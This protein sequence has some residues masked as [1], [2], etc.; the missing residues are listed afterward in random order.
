[1]GS[2]EVVTRVPLVDLSPS[3]G[4]IRDQ[5]LSSVSDILESGAF[6]NGP[7]V[8]EFERA[9]AGYCDTTH[10]VGVANGLDALRL[11][12]QALEVGPGDEVLVPAMTFIATWEAVSQVGAIPVPVDVSPFDYC[13]DVEAASAA[14]SSRTRAVLPVHLYGQMADPDALVSLGE[15]DG[16]DV[17]EDA[18]QAHGARRRGR[19][20]GSVGRAGAFSFYPTKNLGA[21][22]DGGALVTSDDDLAERVR[23][24]REHGQRAKHE[25]RWVGWTSRLDTIQAA[26]VAAKLPYLDALNEQRR[27]AAS[28]YSE[29]LA[30]VGDLVL[31]AVV[32]EGGHVWHVYVLQTD[33]PTGLGCHLRECGVDTGR[34]YPNPPHLTE[35]Y[36]ALG[37]LAGAFP[38]AEGLARRGISIPL[39]PGISERQLD[40]VVS[41]VVGWFARG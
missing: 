25:H 33:D 6:T 32:E 22:G 16:V 7:A 4:A 11:A 10:C 23:A 24:L 30:E 14:V 37:H 28:W 35:A 36:A 40:A 15:R 39:F 18:C 2:P 29:A 27:A 26:V 5:V 9:F 17:V 8:A 38:V 19:V 1:M 3:S 21:M 31:P 13:L 34:H 41:S 20:A 12:L